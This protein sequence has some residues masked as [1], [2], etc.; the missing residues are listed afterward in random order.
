MSDYLI[1]VRRHEDGYLATLRPLAPSAHP[2]AI[3]STGPE[4]IA[5]ASTAPAA[6]LAAITEA[7]LPEIPAEPRASRYAC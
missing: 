3:P 5:T 1:R 6:M 4:I 2:E 7:H